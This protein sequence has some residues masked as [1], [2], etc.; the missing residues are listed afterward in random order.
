MFL[1]RLKF[2]FVLFTLISLIFLF[3]IWY[4]DFNFDNSPLDSK[5]RSEISK[6]H[7]ELEYL[8]FQRFGVRSTIPVIIS[9]KIPAKIYGMAI[10]NQSKK[11]VI[12]LNKKR[13]KESSKYMINDV[14]PHEYAHALMF[15]FNDFTKTN[16]GHTLKWEN[17][18][19]KLNGLKCDRFVDNHDI[20][21]GKT[22]FLY[23]W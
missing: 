10:I 19:K 4:K 3:Y 1:K 6:K 5:I 8:A 2:I 23:N 16:G 17:I 12:Y 11:I 22:K 9:N 13:F 7:K 18:C 21:I 15:V 20:V 14:L